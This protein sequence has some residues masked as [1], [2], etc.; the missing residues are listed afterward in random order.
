M[1]GAEFADLVADI[2]EHK[3]REPITLYREKILDGRNR[4]RGCIAG[5]VEPRFE[6][7]EGDNP[8]A[9][10]ISVNLRRRHLSESQRAMIP[11]RPTCGRAS[12]PI[13]N[14]LQICRR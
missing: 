6:T 5:D 14:L 3:L 10:V 13:W 2:K 9:F 8:L 11:L 12:A 1:E 4:Y 7:F